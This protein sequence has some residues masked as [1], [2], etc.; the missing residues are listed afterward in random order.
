MIAVFITEMVIRFKHVII[1][2]IIIIIIIEKQDVPLRKF[3]TQSYARI[4]REL[5]LSPLLYVDLI[6]LRILG[7]F[8]WNFSEMLKSIFSLCTDPSPQ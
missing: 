4:S 6:S 8:L 3:S 1:I 7:K 5:S 2:I